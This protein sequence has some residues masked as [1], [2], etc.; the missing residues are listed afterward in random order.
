MP[1]H[2]RY[3]FGLVAPVAGT[4]LA[5]TCTVAVGFAVAARAAGGQPASAPHLSADPSQGEGS[6]PTAGVSGLARFLSA[7]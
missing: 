4:S 7:A 3:P 6:R 5:G 2:P 1:E